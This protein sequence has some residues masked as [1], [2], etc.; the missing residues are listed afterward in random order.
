MSKIVIGLSGGMDSATLL[1]YF[2]NEGHE[3]HTCSFQYG[4]KQ[5]KYEE[6]AVAKI[7]EYYYKNGYPVV[8][9]KIN[10]EPAFRD[11]QSNL[12]KTGGEI[13]E[14]H[15]EDESMKLTVV[16]GRNLIF[17]SIMA[18]LAESIGANVIAL[19]V[20]SGDHCLPHYE[21]ILTKKGK[22]PIF[23]LKIGNEVLSQNLETGLVSFKKVQKIVNNGFRNDI[24]K[25]TC[26]GLRSISLT[27]NHKVF[28]IIR[29]DFNHHTGWKKQVLET[30]A[31]QL[32][33]GDWILAPATGKSLLNY[34]RDS[35][36]DLLP[37]CDLS[38]KYL[39]YDDKHIWFKKGNK[40]L[41]NV[42]ASDV[43]KLLAWFIT[44]GDK[45]GKRNTHTNTYSVGI[46]Q[47]IE[48]NSENHK[49]ICKTIENWGFTP[50]LSGSTIWFS[51]P[52]TKIFD[53]CGKGAYNK[54]I[55]DPFLFYNPELLFET[56]LKGDGYIGKDSWGNVRK[57]YI[58]SSSELKEQVSWLGTMLGYSV[59]ISHNNSGGYNIMFNTKFKKKMNAFG[60]SRMVQIKSIIHQKPTM[61]YDIQVEDNH[62][63]FAGT[64]S[65]ILVSNS[66]YPDCRPDFIRSAMDTI[67]HSTGGKVQVIAPFLFDDKAG[68]LQ[69]GYNDFKIQVPYELTRTCYKDQE[70]AC[71]KCGS[72]RERL[73]AFHNIGIDDPIIYE[74]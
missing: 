37:Y 59:G 48:I 15:Y 26:K 25:I 42:L 69:R 60:N 70:Y 68:I 14:G 45:V 11:F 66:I 51:G 32:Q 30:P 8:S 23:N 27:S 16:P 1:G 18:G 21:S 10:L 22:I 17:M 52:T 34:S 19:G 28:Q 61:V 65:G 50:C 73:E 2:L 71:G 31:D 64:G 47:S 3:V 53:L 24:L 43:V 74:A 41:R 58:T 72:C 62:N 49:E 6:I 67:H 57:C 56:L 44:E 4:S 33:V 9:H 5:N 29:S 20:H 38:H 40:V 36:I 54:K 12:L 46:S 13:P 55:P 63:F 39:R 7:L 35:Y